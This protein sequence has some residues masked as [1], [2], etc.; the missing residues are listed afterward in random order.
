MCF[1]SDASWTDGCNSM[2]SLLWDL[3]CPPW[4]QPCSQQ[5]QTEEAFNAKIWCSVLSSKQ[6]IVV[7]AMCFSTLPLTLAR[8]N[9]HKATATREGCWC[10]GQMADGS[11][12]AKWRGMK[13]PGLGGGPWKSCLGSMTWM[14]GWIPLLT[15]SNLA[16]KRL[17][18]AAPKVLHAAWSLDGA[19]S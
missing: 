6:G 19:T 7:G 18:N 10:T 12:V 15:S 5:H 16:L 4:H 14:V 13:V 17:C 2:Q 9:C 1:L 11:T 3:C 8:C